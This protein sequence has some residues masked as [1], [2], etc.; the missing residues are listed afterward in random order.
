MRSCLWPFSSRRLS[1]YFSWLTLCTIT[2]RLLAA[3][4]GAWAV[5]FPSLMSSLAF[6]SF[7]TS[8]LAS[9]S[10]SRT[11]FSAC[12]AW[13]WLG[14]DSSNVL[15]STDQRSR[16]FQCGNSR[17]FLNQLVIARFLRPASSF[18]SSCCYS[19]SQCW[20]LCYKRPAGHVRPSRWRLTDSNL[21]EVP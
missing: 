17:S 21:H 11:R 18:L 8:N 15:S 7:L 5:L 9:V 10:F 2:Y 3:G 19:L 12:K 16:A 14:L 4:K 20:R 13:H 1:T 6:P